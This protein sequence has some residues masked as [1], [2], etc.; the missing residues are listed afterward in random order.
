MLYIPKTKPDCYVSGIVALNIHSHRDTGD[1]H[2][3]KALGSQTYPQ[4][5]YIFGENQERN[6]NHLL[7]TIGII[8]GTERLHK[9]GYRPANT[10][11]WLADHPR[12]CVDYLYATVLTTGSIG[13]VILDDWFPNEEDKRSVY[14]LL[15]LI[16]PRLNL[17]ELENLRLWKLKNPIA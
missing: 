5:F 11:V 1:W 13:R 10:P 4:N 2:S 9:M 7:G 3:A 16:E 8:D 15:T 6:T 12:A 14:D 17:Q